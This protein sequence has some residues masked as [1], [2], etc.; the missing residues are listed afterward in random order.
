MIVATLKIISMKMKDIKHELIKLLA[1][2]ERSG[3]KN[4][5]SILKRY[6]WRGMD[7]EDTAQQINHKINSLVKHYGKC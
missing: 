5:K 7:E 4:T 1:V 3:M 2:N 6:G